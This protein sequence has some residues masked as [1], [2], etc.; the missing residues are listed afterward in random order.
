MKAYTASSKIG[1]V[2]NFVTES[3]AKQ[4]FFKFKVTRFGGFFYGKSTMNDIAHLNM[5]VDST[6]SDKAAKSLDNLA[7]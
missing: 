3:P 6:D 7:D 5:A 1:L 4:V 2:N